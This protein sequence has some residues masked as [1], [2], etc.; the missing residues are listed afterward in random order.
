MRADVIHVM[1][2]GRVIE[3]GTHAE[4]LARGGKYAVS[5]HAQMRTPG[6]G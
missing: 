6:S 2:D 1:E 4:L 5:W 3:S